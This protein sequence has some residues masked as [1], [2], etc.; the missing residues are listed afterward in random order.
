M[1]GSSTGA[2]TAIST[3]TLAIRGRVVALRPVIAMT[4]AER[5]EAIRQHKRSGDLD[6]LDAEFLLALVATLQAEKEAEYERGVE[7]AGHDYNDFIVQLGRLQ[8]ENA[9]LRV[10]LGASGSDNATLLR[11]LDAALDV[12][13]KVRALHRNDH[14]DGLDGFCMSCG[15]SWPCQTVQMLASAPVTEDPKPAMLG[16]LPEPDHD[17][18][19]CY[20]GPCVCGRV[21]VAEDRED[22][23]SQ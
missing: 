11:R 15:F 21:A 7:Q 16:G 17:D 14:D 13:A 4:D 2:T 12:I 6:Y 23:Q 22:Q 9:E 18:M 1:G 20:K 19:A 10:R 3:R 5:L 8:A